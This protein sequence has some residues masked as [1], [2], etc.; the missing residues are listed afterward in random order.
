MVKNDNNYNNSLSHSRLKTIRPTTKI[1]SP[2]EFLDWVYEKNRENVSFLVVRK[3][4]NQ[5]Q[6]QNETAS[7]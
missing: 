4:T 6:N 2:R 3:H 1:G 7:K 5:N